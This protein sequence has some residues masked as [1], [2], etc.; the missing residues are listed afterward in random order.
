[1]Y[2]AGFSFK[3]HFN[4]TIIYSTLPNIERN[5]SKQQTENSHWL[6]PKCMLPYHIVREI[7]YVK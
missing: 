1:M 7:Q 6:H 2:Y 4:G 3:L 5:V